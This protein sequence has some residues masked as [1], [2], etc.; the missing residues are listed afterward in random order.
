MQLRSPSDAQ[1]KPRNRRNDS[2]QN[3]DP[4][5]FKIHNEMETAH[6][7]FGVDVA[8]KVLSSDSH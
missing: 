7:Q 6:G 5:V 3:G 4:Q 1:V 2:F 8:V